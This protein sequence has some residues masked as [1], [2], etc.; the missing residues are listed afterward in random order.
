LDYKKKMK[1][2]DDLC[3]TVPTQCEKEFLLEI[4]TQSFQ[5]PPNADVLM[6][7]VGLGAEAIIVNK[8]ADSPNIVIVDAFIFSFLMEKCLPYTSVHNIENNQENLEFFLKMYNVDAEI[9]NIELNETSDDKRI[10]KEWNFIY[11][12]LNADGS[13]GYD[14][15]FYSL[16]R[17]LFPLLKPNGM[18]FGRNY[19][20]TRNSESD[21]PK[22]TL[23]VRN[24]AT[25]LGCS[26]EHSNLLH[27]WYES[28]SYWILKK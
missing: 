5:F 19:F 16:I 20:H 11:C 10:F 8:F 9:I 15:L 18:I 13:H 25:E 21:K 14:K 1:F 3:S 23:L 22:M 2:I 28:S 4:A 24:I 7:G 12:D 17:K 27:I 6:L 26:L